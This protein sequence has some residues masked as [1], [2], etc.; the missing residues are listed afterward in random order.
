MEFKTL[1]FNRNDVEVIKGLVLYKAFN[2][3]QCS[4]PFKIV[5]KDEVTT[6]ISRP[7]FNKTIINDST[8]V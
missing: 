5:I 1:W 8:A 7:M 6:L 2:V 3:S 4:A